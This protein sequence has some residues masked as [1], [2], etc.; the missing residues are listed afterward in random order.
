MANNTLEKM[1]VKMEKR[2]MLRERLQ[3]M[4]VRQDAEVDKLALKIDNLSCD[5]AA[6]EAE[7]RETADK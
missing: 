3:A 2:A 7:L 4:F 1:I 5:I 6:L